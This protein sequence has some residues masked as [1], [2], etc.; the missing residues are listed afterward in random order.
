MNRDR[1]GVCLNKLA[2]TDSGLDRLIRRKGIVVNV[3]TIR[4]IKLDTYLARKRL[5]VLV[6]NIEEVS[7][8]PSNSFDYLARDDNVLGRNGLSY[9]GD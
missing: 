9:Y 6:P 5:I 7:V 1:S 8:L 4:L 3:F 2:S